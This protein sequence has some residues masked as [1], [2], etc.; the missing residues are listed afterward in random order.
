MAKYGTCPHMNCKNYGK[1][2]KISKKY[3][4]IMECLPVKVICAACGV[5]IMWVCKDWTPKEKEY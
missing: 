3:N 4:D 2:R 1:V 5:E